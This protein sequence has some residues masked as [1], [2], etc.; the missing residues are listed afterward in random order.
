MAVTNNILSEI[1]DEVIFTMEYPINGITALSAYTEGVTGVTGTRTFDRLFRYTLDGI[2]FTEWIELTDPNLA[3]IPVS[4]EHEFQAQFSYTRSGS[5]ATG[6]LVFEWIKLDYTTAVSCSVGGSYFEGSIFSYFLE[7][8]CEDIET[9]K[10]AMNVLNKVYKPGVVSKSLTRGENNNLNFEDDDYIAFWNTVT[11]FFAMHVNYAR[12]FEN[13]AND[14]RL[15]A[16]YLTN[17]AIIVNRDQTIVDMQYVMG[18]LYSYMRHRGTPAIGNLKSRGATVD[19]ELPNLVQFDE[20]RDEFLMDYSKLIWQMNRHSPLYKGIDL[21]HVRKSYQTAIQTID[22]SKYPILPNGTTTVVNLGDIITTVPIPGQIPTG[23]VIRITGVGATQKG[24]IGFVD[25]SSPTTAEEEFLTSIDPDLTYEI[26]F[27]AKGN[28]PFSVGGYGFSSS[29]AQAAVDVI[30]PA[31]QTNYAIS[32][33]KLADPNRWY[34]IRVLLLPGGSPFTGTMGNLNTSIGLGYNLRMPAIA[35]KFAFEI[36]VDRTTPSNN[37][38]TASDSTVEI[39]DS[40]L[41]TFTLQ[42]FTQDYNDAEG[43]PVGSVRL[44]SIGISFGGGSLGVLTWDVTNI[45]GTLPQTIPVA[46]IVAGK[47]TYKDVAGTPTQ[48]V[49][50]DYTLLDNQPQTAS[51]S[52][53]LYVKD[54]TF[55]LAVRPYGVGVV[56]GVNLI[57]TWIKNRSGQSEEQIN[58]K[59]KQSLIPYNT[60]NKNNYLS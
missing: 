35:T 3:A 55:K 16:A 5:D 50:L 20:V 29:G 1:G 51:T 8:A 17:Q 59:I 39:E 21:Y 14:K 43:D 23:Q 13:L 27:L 54:V 34:F 2:N 28:A 22:I 18:N 30:N 40:E 33:Q 48:D 60:K 19:G 49:D 46:D 32:R 26:T 15:I 42:D 6:N 4:P 31:V 25:G 38:P 41:Y 7:C 53:V 45:T 9:K 12:G 10:W 24:G 57:E 56:N 44:D 36:S 52:S 47:L 37:E 11:C 58:N